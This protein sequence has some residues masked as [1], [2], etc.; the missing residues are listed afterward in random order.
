M[1]HLSLPSTRSTRT[2][3]SASAKKNFCCFATLPRVI[4]WWIASLCSIL[5][6]LRDTRMPN[7][8]VCACS[9][10]V[11]CNAHP[12]GAE[13][14]EYFAKYA[15]KNAP[16]STWNLK[17]FTDSVATDPLFIESLKLTSFSKAPT[18]TPSPINQGDLVPSV[19]AQ[20]PRASTTI[21]IVGGGLSALTCAYN[22]VRKGYT[23][24]RMFF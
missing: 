6:P 2:R 13:G 23:G 1:R 24:T 15:K 19:G 20:P 8:S 11:F 9:H 10:L 12:A 7:H 5:W 22:L 18:A 16:E 17:H 14:V 21:A 3:A 4:T